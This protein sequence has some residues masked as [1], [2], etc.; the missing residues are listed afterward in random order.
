MDRQ[1]S[2]EAAIFTIFRCH[3]ECSMVSKSLTQAELIKTQNLE[4]YYDKIPSNLIFRDGATGRERW[5][6]TGTPYSRKQS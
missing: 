5:R 2:Q 1:A 6:V 4:T 3:L